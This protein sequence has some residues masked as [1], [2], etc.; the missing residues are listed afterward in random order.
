MIPS[1]QALIRLIK[2]KGTFFLYGARA[3]GKTTK[4]KDLF[5][6]AEVEY[7][8]LNCTMGDKKANFLKYLNHQL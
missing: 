2:A 7:I 4:L 1:S 8:Y 6:D 3:T 5:E